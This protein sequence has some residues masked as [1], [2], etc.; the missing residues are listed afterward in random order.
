L[1]RAISARATTR[2]PCAMPRRLQWCS[3][4]RAPEYDA[5]VCTPLQEGADALEEAAGLR[6]NFSVCSVVSVAETK[7]AGEKRQN[8]VAGSDRGLAGLIDQVDCHDAMGASHVLRKE[9]RD[10]GICSTIR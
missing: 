1:P 7:T 4:M 9:R 10:I 3:A 2:P 6:V 8:F 5:G